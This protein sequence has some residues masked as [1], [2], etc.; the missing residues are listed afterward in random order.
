MN[1]KAVLWFIVIVVLVA[2]GV[3]LTAIPAPA[4][5]AKIGPAEL[6]QLQGAGAA[7]IDV[8]TAAEYRTGHIPGSLNVPLDTLQQVSAAWNKDQPVVVYCATGARSAQAAA[9]LVGAGFRK[10]YD[11]TGGIAAWTG[12]IEGGQ[13]TGSVPS[14]PGAVKTNGKPLFIDFS[15]ST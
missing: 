4:V 9:Y 12:A 5:N 10:V 1:T 7:V 13:A 3:A 8:R 2:A 14:G 15:G 6:T 11:L